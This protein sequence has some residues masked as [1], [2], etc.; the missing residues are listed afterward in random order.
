MLYQ[1]E[2]YI[3]N[4]NAKFAMPMS[5]AAILHQSNQAKRCVFS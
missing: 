4:I 1:Y 5:M 3:K 2:C